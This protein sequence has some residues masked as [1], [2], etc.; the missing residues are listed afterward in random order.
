[1]SPSLLDFLRHIEHECGFILRISEGKT[2]DDM[3]LYLQMFLMVATEG[4]YSLEQNKESLESIVRGILIT[5]TSH[6]NPNPT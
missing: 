4:L 3:I 2:K 1:M 6:M 5:V